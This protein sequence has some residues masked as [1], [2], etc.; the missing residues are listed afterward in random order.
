MSKRYVTF[1]NFITLLKNSGP[2]SIIGIVFD[3]VALFI[4]LPMVLFMSNSFAEP[5][6]KYDFDAIEKKGTMKTATITD[7]QS[8]DNVTV[9]GRHPLKIIYEFSDNG[10]IKSDAFQTMDFYKVQDFKVERKIQIKIFEN[11]SKIQNLKP[12]AFPFFVF[13]ILPF[14]FFTL[15]LIFLII[16]VIPVLKDYELY[17]NGVVK[18]GFIISMIPNSG[19]PITN[20]GQSILINY[21]YV[22]SHGQKIFGKSKT[23]DFSIMIENKSGDSLKLFVSEKDETKSCMIPKLEAIKNNWK[24]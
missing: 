15:G 18:E 23:K 10:S 11:E 8:V 16:G 4:L 20:I 6:E 2:F 22:G 5:H 13:Y 1:S 7:V 9:N 14:I 21:Y 3:F 12:F 24:V 19:L 17:K